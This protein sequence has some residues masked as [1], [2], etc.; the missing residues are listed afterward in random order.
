MRASPDLVAALVIRRARRE[1]VPALLALYDAGA[2]GGKRED[3]SNLAPYLE[4]FDA[5]A[6]DPSCRLYVA[7]L[8]GRVVGT[9]QLTWLRHLSY[10]GRPTALVEAVHVA[11]EQ[12]GRGIGEVMMRHAIDEA[13]RQGCH[14]IQLTSNK[15]RK[16]AHRFYERLGF[17]A[18]H[19][20]I[21]LSL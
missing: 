18:T 17:A 11:P 16:D 6:A 13:R 8:G 4:A 14:R 1:E 5:I 9:F 12:R 10:G 19:E 21:R 3:L 15:A 2:V 20:G 7:E